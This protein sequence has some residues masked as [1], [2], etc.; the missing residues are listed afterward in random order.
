M[1]K[2]KINRKWVLQN[3]RE[4]IEHIQSAIDEIEAG[5]EHALETWIE[6]IYLDL[7]RAWNGRYVAD[8]SKASRNNALDAFPKDIDLTLPS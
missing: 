6:F 2:K 3:L 5:K 8:I 7:N 1:P 4:T